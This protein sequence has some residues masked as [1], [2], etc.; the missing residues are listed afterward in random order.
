MQIDRLLWDSKSKGEYQKGRLLTMTASSLLLIQSQ[1][2]LR[3]KTS[4]SLLM[5]FVFPSPAPP[6]LSFSPICIL[7]WNPD[8]LWHL[9]SLLYW[10][11]TAF[12]LDF[13]P[14]YSF[15]LLP[16]SMKVALWKVPHGTLTYCQHTLMQDSSHCLSSRFFSCCDW[17]SRS[18]IT[19]I[20]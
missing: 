16:F 8:R 18:C 17:K 20:Y 1:H 7:L 13:F 10:G 19:C 3:N 2:L 6:K 14:S 15:H 11:Q 4:S 12:L 9:G 5:L